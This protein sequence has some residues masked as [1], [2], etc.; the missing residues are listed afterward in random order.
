LEQGSKY[1]QEAY[2]GMGNAQ[3]AMNNIEAADKQYQAALDTDPDYAPAKVGL[4]KVAIEKENYQKAKDLLTLVAEANTTEI[5]AEAQYLL[6]MTHKQQGNYE[7]AIKAF[8][9]VNILY[10][11]YDEWVSKALLEKAK[12]YIQMGQQG[13]ARSELNSLIEDYPGTPQAREA[14]R[15]LN[16]D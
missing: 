1:R 7:D 12:S 6:G 16:T 9:N 8:S 10:E 5:G 4:A 3:L 2:I 13:E 14:K 15:L 11:A